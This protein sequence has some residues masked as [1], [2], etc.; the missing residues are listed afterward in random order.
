GGGKPVLAAQDTPERAMATAALTIH[1]ADLRRDV[2][3]LASDAL[4]GRSTLTAGYDSAAA[5]VARALRAM[6]VR[7]AGDSGGY[8][9]HYTV[10]SSRL[11]TNRV[12]GSIA[13]TPLR[14]GE[15]FVGQS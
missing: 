8:F 14:Y 15:D 10:I 9:Q 2:D 6:G 3:F 4:A 5:Y 7:P 11:D 13:D 12:A 1:A